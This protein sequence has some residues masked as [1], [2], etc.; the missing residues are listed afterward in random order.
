MLHSTNAGGVPPPVK[1]SITGIQEMYSA[2][3]VSNSE[4]VTDNDRKADV[5]HD[6]ASKTARNK[7]D[8]WDGAR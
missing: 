7:D 8:L 1:R 6:Q 4:D 3:K 5:K 2:S